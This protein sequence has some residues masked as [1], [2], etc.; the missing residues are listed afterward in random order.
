MPRPNFHL[1]TADP[2]EAGIFD[3][4][5]GYDD[6]LVA[7][8]SSTIRPQQFGEVWMSGSSTAGASMGAGQPPTGAQPLTYDGSAGY[9]YPLGY[10]AEAY[11]PATASMTPA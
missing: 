10:D 1:H 4:P 2:G 11:V 9:D 8:A 5:A 7:L 6:L 3:Y